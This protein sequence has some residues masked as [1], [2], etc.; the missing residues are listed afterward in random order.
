[1]K[2]ARETYR[3]IGGPFPNLSDAYDFIVGRGCLAGRR[4]RRED[5]LQQPLGTR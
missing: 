1:M 5:S 4:K 3:F 2:L